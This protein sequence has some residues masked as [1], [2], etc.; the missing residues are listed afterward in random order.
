M[1]QVNL[2]VI[3]LA[4][5]TPTCIVDTEAALV[6]AAP[7]NATVRA[8]KQPVRLLPVSA[9]LFDR[10]VHESPN[11]RQEMEHVAAARSKHLASGGGS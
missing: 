7:R 4:T 9:A 5:D 10:L 3:G 6:H 8:G 2:N 1:K 11:F